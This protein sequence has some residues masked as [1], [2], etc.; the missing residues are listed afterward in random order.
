MAM[1]KTFKP[2]GMEKI[3][4][5]MGYQG[6]MQ[7]FQD[8]VSQDP[9]RQQQMQNYTNQAMQMAKGG[10]TRKKF[11]EGGDAGDDYA[12]FYQV[13]YGSG[14]DMDYRRVYIGSRQDTMEN[15]QKAG[16]LPRGMEG[17]KP[18]PKAVNHDEYMKEYNKKLAELQGRPDPYAAEQ[19]DLL[20]QQQKDYDAAMQ[21][22]KEEEERQKQI[23][24]PSKMVAKGIYKENP[25]PDIMRMYPA[26][27]P[28]EGFQYAYNETG[29]RITV[30]TDFGG[31]TSISDSNQQQQNPTMTPEQQQQYSQQVAAQMQNAFGT[32]QPMQTNPQPYVPPIYQAPY[33]SGTQ[34]TPAGQYVQDPNTGQPVPVAYTPLNQGYGAAANNFYQQVYGGYGTPQTQY[35]GGFGGVQGNVSYNPNTASAIG[36]LAGSMLTQNMAEGGYVKNKKVKYFQD[37]GDAGDDLLDKRQPITGTF[38]T[39]AAPTQYQPAFSNKDSAIPSIQGSIPP[40]YGPEGTYSLTGQPSKDISSSITPQQIADAQKFVAAGGVPQMPDYRDASQYKGGMED[41]RTSD[42]PDYQAFKDWA[43]K[44]TKPRISSSVIVPRIGPDG[45][46]INFNSPA[47]AEDY[48]NYLKSIGKPPTTS[49]QQPSIGQ[50]PQKQLN[51]PS[52]NIGVLGGPGTGGFSGTLFVS[53]TSRPKSEQQ[54]QAEWQRLVAS[55]KDQRDKGFLGEVILDGEGRYEDWAN[56]NKYEMMRNPDAPDSLYANFDMTGIRDPRMPISA[57]GT[58]GTPGTPADYSGM[59]YEHAQMRQA[60]RDVKSPEEQA[61]INAALQRGPTGQQQPNATT[62]RPGGQVTNPAGTQA[63]TPVYT[64]ASPT[65]YNVTPATYYQPGDD[66]PEG[67]KAGDEKTPEIRYPVPGVAQFSVEQMYNPALPIGGTTIAAQTQTDPSQ[68]IAAGTGELTGSVSVPTA[69]AS[70]TQAQGITPTDANIMQAAQAAPAVDS[71]MNATQAAQADPNNPNA[72]IAAAQQTASSVGNLQAAQGNASLIN[73]P[74]QRQIQQ[75]EL[76]SGVANAQTASQFTEQ[77]QAAQATPSQQATVQGQLNNLMQQFQGGNTPTWAA[78]A[79]RS[80]TSAMAARGLSA[81]SLAGQAMVQAAME[82]ALPIAQADAQTQAQFEGQN[83]SN[84]QQRAMLA[85]QQRAQ[86]MGQEFDQAFQSR[87]QNSA[88]IGDIANMNFTAEQQ[89]QL[90]NSRAVNTMNLNNLSNIQAMVMAEASAL[91]QLDTANLSNRQ[92]SAV[93]NAQNFLQ[94]DMAN[95]SNRQQTELFKAQ[96]RVQSLFTDQAAT[97]AAAQFNATSQ[98]QVDQF[99][100]SLGSQ[101]SQ[102]NAT[103]QNAQAQFNAGQTNTVNRFNAELN[104]QRDQF[105]ATN[106]LVIAQS[107]AQWRR[108]I[109]TADT[110][111]VNRANELNANAVL[112]IS[113][114]AYNNLWNYYSDT[115]E[116][117]W[118]S[119][120]K[121]LD[122]LNALA[123]AQLSADAQNAASAAQRSSSAGSAIGTLIGTLGTAWLKF[124]CWVALEVYGA[125]DIRWFVFRN[126]LHNDAPKWFKNLYQK[127]GEDFA[128]YIKDKPALKWAIRK[129]MDVIVNKKLKKRTSYAI[130]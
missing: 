84:R 23:N 12:N 68:D 28:P 115:M 69:T 36:N 92:Q 108:Q 42:L 73:N 125:K 50:L 61:A 17:G 59:T 26:V 45:K 89:V 121:E 15:R 105:N 5:S 107:N 34:F 109:A 78:A 76:I 118:T 122:R 27:E 106:Q 52:M 129:I 117:A 67:K 29:E 90:E 46:R 82:S 54:M 62:G 100:A 66:I 77:I 101:V 72:Q 44:N 51:P 55:A 95:L 85:A 57:D 111:A 56:A 102:F 22:R 81:S 104:N 119:A 80:V 63:G 114:T 94:Y 113:K 112:D 83:L 35:L 128:K 43:A 86:F 116:W 103:Q 96:Q 32:T 74:V 25:R 88:R 99:F 14:K 79:M 49:A 124:G 91:A 21:R 48:D 60:Q 3:A 130:S 4:R 38:T 6:N 16:N 9:M 11:Q 58:I 71:A 20:A 65:Q 24:D 127:H 37:G 7:G 39:P 70:T 10:M 93:Q 126:W 87:V 64:G 8:Y 13:P 31:W 40:M 75:G 30:P 97:N 110:A 123:T 1:F 41:R 33:L 47:E 2:S 19:E 120:E 98:N 53:D 18:I